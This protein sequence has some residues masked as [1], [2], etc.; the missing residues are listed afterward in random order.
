MKFKFK[1]LEKIVGAFV[2]LSIGFA[3]FAILAIGKGQGWFEK[4]YPYRVIFSKGYGLKPGATVTLSGIDIGLINSV[5]LTPE[6]IVEVQI[7]VEGRY[8]DRIRADSLALVGGPPLLGSKY[9]EII[10]G[11]SEELPIEAGGLIKSEDPKELTDYLEGFDV[12]TVKTRFEEVLENIAELA[13][14]LNTSSQELIV[15]LSNIEEITSRLNEGNAGESLQKTL[16]NLENISRTLSESSPKIKDAITTG[17]ESL[18]EGKKVIKAVQK[19]W[20]IRGNIPQIDEAPRLDLSGRDTNYSST[21]DELTN[22]INNF[23]TD[24]SPKADKSE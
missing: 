17:D 5:G 13:S 7:E 18:K 6:N 8:R 16:T 1:H 23:E 9:L 3:L 24:V 2:F 21:P 15:T 4:S 11:S 14:R 19:S 10:P 22:K 12:N 20:F